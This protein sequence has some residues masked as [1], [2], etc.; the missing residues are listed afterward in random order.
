MLDALFRLRAD[1]GPTAAWFAMFIAAVI[2]ILAVYLGIAL[3]ATLRATDKERRE[4]CYKVFRDLLDL[5]RTGKH[6]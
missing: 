2:I 1:L 5:F 3:S 6:S 4:V